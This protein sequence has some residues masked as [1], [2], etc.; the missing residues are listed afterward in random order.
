MILPVQGMTKEIPLS[1]HTQYWT[2]FDGVYMDEST[3]R[4]Y[5]FK[6]V[7]YDKLKRN[8]EELLI[9]FEEYKESKLESCGIFG[10]DNV[11]FWVG[12]FL[13]GV[14]VGYVSGR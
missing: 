1:E 4:D 6:A 2:L 5:V 14:A 9:D 7:S 3:Y 11:A 13:T 12:I 10:S 8:H